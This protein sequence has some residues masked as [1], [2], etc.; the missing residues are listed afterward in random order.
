MKYCIDCVHFRQDKSFYYFLIIP[1]MWVFFYF[2]RSDAIRFG[3][4]RKDIAENWIRLLSG[5]F[6]NNFKNNFAVVYR[7]FDC[8]SEGKFW[9][10]KS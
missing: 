1:F 9:E 4:C 2:L 10:Q 8:G 6:K 5:R 3:I 7:E